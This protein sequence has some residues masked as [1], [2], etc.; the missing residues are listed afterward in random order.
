MVRRTLTFRLHSYLF[1][2]FSYLRKNRELEEQKSR[3]DRQS[4]V[5]QNIPSSPHV[6]L[7]TKMSKKGSR[8]PSGPWGRLK[9]V[10]QDPLEAMGLPSK[11]DK[12]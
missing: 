8:I 7:L 3:R 11:G 9:P 6:Y 12:R 1:I 5:F 2:C 10:E 4:I